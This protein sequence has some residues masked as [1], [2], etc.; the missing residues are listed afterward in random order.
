[1]QQQSKT[2]CQKCIYTCLYYLITIYTL[3]YSNLSLAK[4]DTVIVYILE[5]WH[6][7]FCGILERTIAE[8]RVSP[9]LFLNS[10][11]PIYR[12]KSFSFVNVSTETS[13]SQYL[14]NTFGIKK[15]NV[16]YSANMSSF[17][18]ILLGVAWVAWLHRHDTL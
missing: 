2:V 18:V 12:T 8:I 13:R 4:S 10:N 1:M 9:F 5:S 17:T 11:R 15:I 7:N 16:L 3:H 6:I 14:N